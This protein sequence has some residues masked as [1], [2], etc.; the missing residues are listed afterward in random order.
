MSEDD[1]Y[2]EPTK[3]MSDIRMG[4]LRAELQAGGSMSVYNS[5]GHG[6]EVFAQRGNEAHHRATSTGALI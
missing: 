3:G 2:T 5:M 4:I 6:D 1:E